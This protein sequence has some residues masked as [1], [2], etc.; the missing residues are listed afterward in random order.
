MTLYLICA[1]NGCKNLLSIDIPENI[2]KIGDSHLFSGCSALEEVTIPSGVS[3]I[4][5]ATFYNCIALQLITFN[6]MTA[7]TLSN[8]AFG[9]YPDAGYFP[10][11][12]KVK[13]PAAS[14]GYIGEAASEAW[15]ALAD[16]LEPIPVTS[17]KVWVGGTQV[18]SAN[19][20]DVLSDGK[21][22]YNASTNILTLTDADITTAYEFDFN[23]FSKGMSGIYVKGDLN[24]VLVGSSNIGGSSFDTTGAVSAGIFVSEGDLNISGAGSLTATAGK[25]EYDSTGVDIESFNKC[26]TI[27]GGANVTAI[28]GTGFNSRGVF[29]NGSL[30]I[31]GGSLTAMGDS[32]GEKCSKLRRLW[33]LHK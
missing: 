24:L 5:H 7:P 16:K 15:K 12:L 23:P 10:K 14:S 28:G 31:D 19:A 13:I 21:V 11:D 2:T 17:Y 27:S 20:S 8:S 3:D 30:M 22:S 25:A 32:T 1:F 4:P 29:I 33:W 18:T 9:S 6:R 26:L